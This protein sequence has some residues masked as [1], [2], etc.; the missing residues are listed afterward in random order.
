[1]RSGKAPAEEPTHLN[2]G[3]LRDGTAASADTIDVYAGH[4]IEIETAIGVRL[5]G[6]ERGLR[7]GA[8]RASN[9]VRS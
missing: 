9:V 8:W 1:M 7:A 2:P 4:P 3:L 5:R 6:L